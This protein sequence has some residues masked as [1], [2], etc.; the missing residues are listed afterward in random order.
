[1]LD[2]KIELLRQVPL[3]D[4]LPDD[5]IELIADAGEKRYFE[6]G[7]NLITAGETGTTAFLILTGKAGWVRVEQGENI[8]EDIW[9]GTLVGEL[10]M[11]VETV[12]AVTVTAQERLRALALEQ[13]SLRTVM[14]HHP[15]I[16]KYIAEKLLLRLQGLA[17]KLREVDG[18]LA[19]AE[20]AA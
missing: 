9:P 18:K 10:G 3:F 1:M 11:L 5:Q 14:E 16:A 12:H 17:E 15:H 6:A 4:G 7:E 20:K 19:E 2:Q 8:L 13:S